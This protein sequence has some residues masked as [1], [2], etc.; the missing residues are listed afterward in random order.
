MNKQDEPL[1]KELGE[2][3]LLLQDDGISDSLF[4]SILTRIDEINKMLA[5]P[6]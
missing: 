1:Y 2:L 4:A 5:Y 6:G 3:D